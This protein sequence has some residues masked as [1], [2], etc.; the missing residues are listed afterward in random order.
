MKQTRTIE[1]N[2]EKYTVSFV[3]AQAIH[4]R[5]QKVR[6][7]TVCRIA[8]V[9]GRSISMGLSYRRPTEPFNEL[10]GRNKAFQRAVEDLVFSGPAFFRNAECKG[11]FF[12]AFYSRPAKEAVKPV[13]TFSKAD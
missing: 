4:P 8:D 1:V 2:G 5:L 11:R 9:S 3:H 13:L 6:Q 10:E 12:Q 7:S